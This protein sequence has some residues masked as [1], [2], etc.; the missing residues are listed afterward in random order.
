MRPGGG[1]AVCVCVCVCVCVHVCVCVCVQN[2]HE[3]SAVML[4][5]SNVGMPVNIILFQVITFQ[6]QVPV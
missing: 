5:S 6:L 2:A 1:K 3:H 4:I